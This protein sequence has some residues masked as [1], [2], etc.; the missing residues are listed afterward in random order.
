MSGKMAATRVEIDHQAIRHNLRLIEKRV[1]PA[2]VMAVIKANAYGHGAVELAE[3]FSR[4]GVRRFAVATPDEALELRQH[5]ISGDI[6]LFGAH[7][8]SAVPDLIQNDIILTLNELSAIDELSRRAGRS[9]KVMRCHVNVDT[10]MGRAGMLPRD[11]PRALEKCAK[12]TMLRLEGLYT[13]FS[14][15]DEED[16]SHTR[17]QI[18]RFKAM[19]SA[20]GKNAHL[21]KHMANSAAIMRFPQS[22]ADVVR[23]GIMLYGN[24]PSPDFVTEWPLREAMQFKSYVSLI[25]KVKAGSTVSY[26]RRYVTA[27]E[28]HLALVPVGY[29]DG[30]MRAMTGKAFVLIGGRRL[31]VS[32]TVTMDQLVI[33]L[34]ARTTVKPGDEV[35][36]FGRQGDE[37][38]SIN[39]VARWAGTIS[40]EVTCSVSGRVPRRHRY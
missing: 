17:Q 21:L 22:Y 25:K 23:P 40:Y 31:A 34:G 32:G 37:F 2:G 8:F 19:A 6:L 35:V 39:E 14:S 26:N 11:L 10:G 38:I 9:G 24:L 33:D 5:N 30:Y 28:T 27:E 3:T 13:H 1:A 12:E 7:D 15:A 18:E 36:L 16:A 29:A 20:A 4:M